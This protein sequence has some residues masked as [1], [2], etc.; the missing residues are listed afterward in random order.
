MDDSIVRGTT[1]RKLIQI[2]KRIC[3]IV[4]GQE[5]EIHMRISSPPVCHPCPYGINTP[6]HQELIANQLRQDGE[7]D[8]E[9]IRQHIGAASLG[10]VTVEDLHASVANPDD[11]CYACWTGDYPIGT[12]DTWE[13]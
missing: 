3:R 9:A 10:Y 6:T 7:V 1:T 11:Y 8:V 2:L 12:K 5:A 4:T 13:V